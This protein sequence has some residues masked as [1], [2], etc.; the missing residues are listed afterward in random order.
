MLELRVFGD[1]QLLGTDGKPLDVITRQTKRF[2]VLIYLVCDGALRPHRREE[3]LPVFWPESD[4]SSGRNALR[5]SLHVIRDE[6]GQN[7]VRGNGTEDIWVE[8]TD[9]RC[10]VT[11]FLQAIADGYPEAAL[12]AYKADFLLG[13]EVPGCPG[14]GSWADRRR[15]EL[16]DMANAGARDLAHRAEGVRDSASA[17][18][19]WRRVSRLSPFDERVIRRIMS[20]LAWNEDRG[21]AVSEFEA[22]RCRLVADLGLEPS[23]GTLELK[24]KISVGRMARVTRWVGD[25]R[26]EAPEPAHR[27][28]RR[29]RD[30]ARR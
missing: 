6:L 29:S 15:T 16:R 22:F 4:R 24:E 20:L 26:G 3:L 19:W 5:Q 11:A 23:A 27:P 28:W 7:L 10:D 1:P 13:F 25:R 21:G 18:Y 17:L 2:A 30:R 9:L 8:G 12:Q 14:F